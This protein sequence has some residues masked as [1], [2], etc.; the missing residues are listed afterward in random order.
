MI[1]S[2]FG[3]AVAAAYV[4]GRLAL[5]ILDT[6]GVEGQLS[7]YL[8]TAIGILSGIATFVVLW[9]HPKSSEFS[10]DVIKELKKVTWP[11]LIETRASTIVVI[12]MTI[13]MS[14][15]FGLFDYIFAALTNIIYS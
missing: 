4:L 8:P 14:L 7:K 13:I 9:K 1:L 12:V 3:A 2:F 11:T 6:A 5:G 15:I 10:Q